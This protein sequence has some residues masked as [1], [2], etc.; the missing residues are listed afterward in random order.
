MDIVG[1]FLSQINNAYLAGK[2]KVKT[3]WS[4]FR[5][6]LAKIILKEGYL[7]KV[8]T[9]KVDKVKKNLVLTLKYTSDQQPIVTKI[10]R[11]S[12][13]G[14]RVYLSADK[15]PFTFGGAGSTI[16]STS[17]GLTTAKKAKAKNIGGEVICQ[18][19]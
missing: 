9:E 12:T 18:I 8:E 6:A 5:E 2:E 17:T 11:V 10:K 16:I 13:P 14:R 3:P 15:L 1:N 19:Y 4:K 7:G